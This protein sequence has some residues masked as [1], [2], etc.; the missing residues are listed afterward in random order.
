MRLAEAE[1]VRL[2]LR[3]LADFVK[4][5]GGGLL[6]LS[7]EHGTPAAVA[8]SRMDPRSVSALDIASSSMRS[9]VTG[10]N[11]PSYAISRW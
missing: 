4:Q 3:D 9:S 10:S 11:A 7:G 6:F 1:V 2:P 8:A 5:K